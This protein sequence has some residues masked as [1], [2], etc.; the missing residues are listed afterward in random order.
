MTAADA[1]A[2]AMAVGSG[3]VIVV[4]GG[5]VLPG[6]AG[7]VVMRAMMGPDRIL[8]P[9]HEEGQGQG[10][11][12]RV[13]GEGKHP[14]NLVTPGGPNSGWNASGAGGFSHGPPGFA[15]FDP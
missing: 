7:T 12:D 5:P 10:R 15:L 8:H 13:A 14:G 1:R 3:P 2:R 6:G 9:A 4:P 11:G